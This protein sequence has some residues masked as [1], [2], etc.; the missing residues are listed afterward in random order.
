MTSIDVSTTSKA[1]MLVDDEPDICL[2]FKKSLELAGYEVFAFTKPLLALVHFKSNLDR[3]GL[4]V[5]DVRMPAM[6]GIE[7]AT[8]IRKI[9]TSIPIMLMS[10]FELATLNIAPAL[11]IAGFLEKPLGPSKLKQAVSKYIPMPAK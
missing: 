9:D 8:Q 10:A 7:L 11:N 1:I 6:S 2:V 4:I 5:S 3:Y